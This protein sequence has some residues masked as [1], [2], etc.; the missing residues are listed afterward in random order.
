MFDIGFS[1]V[2][3][4]AVISLVVLGPER[5]P[6]AAR[7]A[8]AWIG[9]AR[10]IFFDLKHEVES[11]IHAKEIQERLSK[12]QQQLDQSANALTQL[13]AENPPQSQAPHSD[14]PINPS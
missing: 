3:L 13:P 1:E 8:G 14:A 9:K 11:E 12:I 10:R 7:L 2:L 5:L 6:H 4:L